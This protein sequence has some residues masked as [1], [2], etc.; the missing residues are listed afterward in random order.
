MRAR[1]IKP[2]FFKNEDLAE[3]KPIDRLFFIGMWCAVDREGRIVD[4]PKRIKM[5]IMPCDNYDAEIGIQKLEKFGF[6]ERYTVNEQSIIQIVNFHKHQSPHSLEKDSLLPDRNGK[7]TV[8][9]R[10]NGRVCS[11]KKQFFDSIDEDNKQLD[12]SSITE[13]TVFD[14]TP[15]VL[16]VLDLLDSKSKS[17]API[18][19][20]RAL[21]EIQTWLDSLGDQDAIPE[22][23][24]IFDYAD[25]AGIPADFLAL[26][27]KRF[28]E[29]M[30]ERKTK[31]RDWRAHYRNAV[32]GNWFKI[33][34]VDCDGQYRLTTVGEQA[35]RA[36]A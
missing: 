28:V 12:N 1:N 3:L 22:S 29:D 35:R 9:E 25:K 20:K 2:G 16:D 32:R 7:I 23:D 24:P 11:A 27:W 5:D 36:V 15:D 10:K 13:N 4:R 30:T 8:N 17:K 14:N 19:T 33:W 26:S 6:V 34:W 18:S 21:L 31:K